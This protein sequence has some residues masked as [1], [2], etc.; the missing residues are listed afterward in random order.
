MLRKIAAALFLPFFI[1]SAEMIAELNVSEQKVIGQI[2]G[3]LNA[4]E[5]LQEKAVAAALNN[6]GDFLTEIEYF[7]EEEGDSLSVIVTG[8]P[9]RYTNFRLK[10][11]ENSPQKAD[12]SIKNGVLTAPP[13]TSKRE[14]GF[15]FSIKGFVAVCAYTYDWDY[16]ELGAN[17][18]FGGF[19][20]RF[21]IAGEAS[22][23]LGEEYFGSYDWYPIGMGHGV[24]LGWLFQPD[25]NFQV[26]PGI[27]GGMWISDFFNFGGCFVKTL[28]GKG[29][30]W[31]EFQY[32]ILFGF[33]PVHKV[34]FGFTRAPSKNF[35]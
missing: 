25:D 2:K 28:F 17:I 12:L 10:G 31:F 18:S 1:F 27:T 15:Y 7:Y 4:K 26:I 29:K 16:K 20:K 22:L 8:F 13:E 32:N 30:I 33:E 35:K 11:L 5:Y 23:F 14:P 9:V 24:L 21:L 3:L 6:G 19:T 34:S